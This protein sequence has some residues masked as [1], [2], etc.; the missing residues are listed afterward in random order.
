MRTLVSPSLS[1]RKGFALPLAILLITVLTAALAAGFAGTTSEFVSNAA[2][3][4]QARAVNLAETG[5]EQ[6]L[7]LRSQSGF[8][9]HC[10]DPVTADSE[11]TR[12]SLPGG[13]ADVV[14]VRVR[15]EIDSAR[16]AFY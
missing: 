16:P 12:V 5:L 2:V 9:A 1:S 3:R 8:C 6:F 14:A 4:G 11:W 7:A 10:S 13:Y 15:P